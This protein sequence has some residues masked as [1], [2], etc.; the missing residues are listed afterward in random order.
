MPLLPGALLRFSL[1][2]ASSISL[3]QGG[4]ASTMENGLCVSSLDSSDSG[5]GRSRSC[6][7]CLAHSFMRSFVSMIV[8]P[9]LVFRFSLSGF[10]DPDSCF[11]AS[12]LKRTD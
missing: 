11:E 5:T 7:K 6:S 4:S 9:S 12:C 10:E 1:Y 8:I 3:E 2:M